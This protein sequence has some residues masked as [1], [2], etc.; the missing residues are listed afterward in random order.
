[1]P[2]A[3]TPWIDR[4][5]DRQSGASSLAESKSNSVRGTPGTHTTSINF[6]S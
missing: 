4:P 6:V 1:M 2:G 3:R 5:N